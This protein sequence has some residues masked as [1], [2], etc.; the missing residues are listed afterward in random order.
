MP[1]R[2]GGALK[3]Q[4][5]K[6]NDITL[7]AVRKLPGQVDGFFI[8]MYSSLNDHNHYLLATTDQ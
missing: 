8:V 3:Y 4:N 7:I 2:R 6:L 5:A 1:P